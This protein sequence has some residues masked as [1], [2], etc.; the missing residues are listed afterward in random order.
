[1]NFRA[2]PFQWPLVLKWTGGDP[3]F[4]FPPCTVFCAETL[5][6]S[7]G[8]MNRNLL[9]PLPSPIHTGRGLQ[10]DVVYLSWPIAPLIYKPKCRGRGWV[11]GSQPMR[12][13]V[14][15]TWHGAQINFED[16]TPYLTYA[17]RPL[18][19]TIKGS[20][21]WDF[22]HQIF[23]INQCPPGPEYP[24]RAI[25]NFFENSQRYL[26]MNVHQRCQRHRQK[27][28]KIVK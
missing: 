4:P 19:G 24:I 7:K 6:Q 15:I 27:K 22:R 14:R 8:A 3:P 9:Q 16:L 17:Y 23:F 11:A 5:E 2:H 28:R 18:D 10:G 21:T 26:R 20:L 25:S 13:A 1:M 12:T